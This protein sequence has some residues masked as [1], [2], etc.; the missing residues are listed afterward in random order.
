MNNIPEA[1]PMLNLHSTLRRSRANGPG[2]R[3]VI[4]FQGCTRN[5]PGCFNP[6]THT[7]AMRNNMSVNEVVDRIRQEGEA[8]EGVTISGG[9]PLE[10]PDGFVELLLAIRAIGGLSTLVFS[11]YPFKEIQ[12]MPH[13]PAVLGNVDVLIAGPYNPAMHLGQRMLGS[14]N[15]TINLLTPR[16]T[17]A[18]IERV[19]TSEI[20]MSADGSIFVTGVSPVNLKR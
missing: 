8:I 4:W 19:P 7:H 12:N 1:G 11:G 18:D 14:T 2:V 15:Q 5:C 17:M 13:G 10:Q 16:Y 9:E 3:F 20:V 6:E